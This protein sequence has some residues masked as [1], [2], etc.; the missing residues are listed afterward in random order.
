MKITLPLMVIVLTVAIAV[1]AI[2]QQENITIIEE[3]EMQTID[4]KTSAFSEGEIIPVKYTCDSLDVSVPLVWSAPPEGTVSFALICDDPDA[5]MGTWVHWVLFN[6]PANI[7]E[8]PEGISIAD[9]SSFAS[10]VE[11]K[12]DFGKTEY[13]GPC[14]PRGPAHR[15][16]FKIYALDTMLDLD[17]KADKA[18][19]EKA[20][21]GHILAQ[22]QIM[23][24]YKR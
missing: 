3:P 9:D 11:G 14:P 8:L 22:G 23:G 21:K 16:Y 17:K 2:C 24:K 10:A 1:T 4:I 5:P 6:I 19:V 15:Y 12:N 13:G 7:T 18:D 20:M